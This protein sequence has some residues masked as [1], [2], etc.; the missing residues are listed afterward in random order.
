[1]SN[2]LKPIE[3]LGRQ[4]AKKDILELAKQHADQLLQNDH[5]LLKIYVELKRYELYLATMINELKE[6][7][8]EKARER[9]EK[10]L[11]YANAKIVVGK[12]TK[13]N[14]ERDMKWKLLNEELERAKKEKKIRENLLKKVEGEFSEAVDAQTG[15]VDRLVAPLKETVDQIIVKL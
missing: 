5:D 3:V 13:Y 4:P 2:I 12:R 6:T 7:T 9:G 11:N 15:E 14:Y 10:W 8:T 1:M